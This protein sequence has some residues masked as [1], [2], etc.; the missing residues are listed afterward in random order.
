[1]FVELSFASQLFLAYVRWCGSRAPVVF[2]RGAHCNIAKP[3]CM[4]VAAPLVL[5]VLDR[6]KFF[7]LVQS[8]VPSVNICLFSLARLL[9]Q[10]MNFVISLPW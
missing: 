2:W 8:C 9:D 3:C 10:N 4:G 5:L 6:S 7:G 1:M